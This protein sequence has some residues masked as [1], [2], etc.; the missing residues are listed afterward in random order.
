VMRLSDMYEAID[1]SIIVLMGALIPVT[2]AMKTTGLTEQIAAGIAM[3]G[4]GLAPLALLAFIFVATLLITPIVNNAATVLLMGPIAGGFATNLGLSVDPF[5]M[6]VAIAASCE[7]LTPFGHQ[8][9]VLVLGPGG[10]RFGDYARLGVPLSIIVTLV[11]VPLI[12]LV[13]PFT[14]S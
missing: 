2:E 9:N 14:A 1:G 5:L 12:A 8:S 4:S 3:V 11:A 13:W 10:Y 6:A 7:F